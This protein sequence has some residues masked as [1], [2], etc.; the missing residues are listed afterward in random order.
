MRTSPSSLAPRVRSALI[1]LALLATAACGETDPAAQADAQAPTGGQVADAQ[2]PPEDAAGGGMQTP[3]LG[4]G[5]Q[6]P[7]P[8][9]RARAEYLKNASPPSPGSSSPRAPSSSSA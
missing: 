2:P 1:G 5:A 9:P 4:A 6:T 7:H 3:D 8:T